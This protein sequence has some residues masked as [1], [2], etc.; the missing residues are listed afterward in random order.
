MSSGSGTPGS[1]EANADSVCDT[2]AE[3]RDP[4]QIAALSRDS[5]SRTRVEVA[6]VRLAYALDTPKHGCAH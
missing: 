1:M 4:K 3:G 2:T 6:E 5:A